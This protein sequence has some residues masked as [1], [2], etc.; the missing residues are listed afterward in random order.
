M[1][2]V[3]ASTTAI[4][5]L[6]AGELVHLIPL[7]LVWTIAGCALQRLC[8]VV[9]WWRMVHKASGN[10][11]FMT[12]AQ[13]T[14][15]GHVFSLVAVFM[16]FLPMFNSRIDQMLVSCYSLLDTPCNT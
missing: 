12:R 1:A 2:C 14:L 3:L 9:W 4:G 13:M 8:M 11:D 16:V 15:V 5:M 7:P 6:I 10:E